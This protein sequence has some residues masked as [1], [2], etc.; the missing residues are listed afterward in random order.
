M[1]RAEWF[2]ALSLVIFLL[3]AGCSQSPRPA[4][5]EGRTPGDE[6]VRDANLADKQNG[7]ALRLMSEQKYSEAE[8]ALRAALKADVTHGPAHNHLGKIYYRQRKFYLAAWEFQY[9][10]K[11]MP[12]QPEP[13]NNLGLVFEEVG[14]LDDAVASYSEAVRME[15]ENPLLV[16]NLARAQ[17]RRGDRGDEVAGLLQTLIAT[18]TRSTWVAWAKER[19][20]L[21]NSDVREK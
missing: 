14:K 18:D 4:A 6:R 5:M 15:P 9:A 16:G 10:I 7:L 20:T 21:L 3:P 17:I 19:L 13:R 11:L 8:R 12:R 1:R 2:I